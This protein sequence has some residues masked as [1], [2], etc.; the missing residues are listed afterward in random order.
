MPVSFLARNAR[1]LLPMLSFVAILL[2]VFWLQPRAMGYVGLN[3]LLNLALADRLCNHRPDVRHHC[4]RSRFVAWLL[5]RIRR[6]RRRHL[7]HRAAAARDRGAG[8][9]Y[10]DL[11][12]GRR[13]DPPQDPAIHRGDAWHVLRLAGFGDPRFADAWR[14][15]TGVAADAD[16]LEDTPGAV[17]DLRSFSL[18]RWSCILG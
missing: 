13:A 16:D 11:C 15:G 17:H 1:I 5:C 14:Q 7:A 10:S 18:S 2:A 12:R 9:R 3:L 8:R 6:L 4:E